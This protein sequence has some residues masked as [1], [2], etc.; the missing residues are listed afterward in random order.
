MQVG[1]LDVSVNHALLVQATEGFGGLD[2]QAQDLRHIEFLL[3]VQ[4]LLQGFSTVPRI[5]QVEGASLLQSRQLLKNGYQM[6]GRAGRLHVVRQPGLM[7]QH[8]TLFL[9]VG[10]GWVEGFERVQRAGV[11]IAHLHQHIDAVVGH[12]GSHHQAVQHVTH[13]ETCRYRQPLGGPVHV[14][15]RGI[16]QTQHAHH[17]G[18]RVVCAAARQSGI[19][20]LLADLLRAGSNGQMSEFSQPLV[21]HGAGHTVG[22]QYKY[23]THAQVALLIVHHHMVFDPH[24][25]QQLVLE[26][27]VRRHMVVRELGGFAIA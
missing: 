25:A 11:R 6:A 14:M 16:Q 9:V 1:G 23:I 15:Q 18:G 22:H 17:H 21:P 12:R 20:Q 10:A 5:Q 13:F 3:A 26:I 27:G 7:R 24:T 2:R 19:H 4:L 8:G